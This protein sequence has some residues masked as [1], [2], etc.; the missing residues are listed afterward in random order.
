MTVRQEAFRGA[1]AADRRRA[2]GFMIGA[3][4]A[5]AA[6]S[7]LAKLQIGPLPVIEVVF[8][9][10]FFAW[11]PIVATIV[12]LRRWPRTFILR[13]HFTR[14]VL[15]FLGLVS[16]FTALQFIPLTD[17]TAISYTSPLIL[18]LLAA[19]L[20]G[21]KLKASSMTVLLLGFVGVIMM[22][23]IGSTALQVGALFA[24]A[25]AVFG[26]FVSIAVRRMS[27]S[28]APTTLVFYQLAT[29]SL[30]SLPIVLV[31]GFVMPDAIGWLMLAGVGGFSAVGQF[32]WAQAFRHGSAATVAPFIYTSLIWVVL[33]DWLVWSHLPGLLLLA[34]AAVVIVCASYT[35]YSS[36]QP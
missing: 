24:L 19:P 15:G 2:I 16:M 11:I 28:E 25:N 12:A 26:A 6:A 23:P 4:S 36:N 20:L 5:F 9:R 1:L 3:T 14:G 33:F 18:S 32:C 17:A 30:I 34:G 10:S 21:E 8:F 31:W 29:S 22:F 35:L 13:D 7:A 27:L